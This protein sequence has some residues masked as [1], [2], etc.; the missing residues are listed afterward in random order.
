MFLSGVY[1]CVK[2]RSVN[3]CVSSKHFC[4]SVCVCRL[5]SRGVGVVSSVGIHT[6][7]FISIVCG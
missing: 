1:L 6:L 2:Y 5:I 3:C 7:Y 4:H